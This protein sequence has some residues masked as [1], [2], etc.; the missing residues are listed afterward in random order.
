MRGIRRVTVTAL[1]SVVTVALMG[2]LG[3]QVPT[4]P[5]AAAIT[6][7]WQTTAGY[8]PLTNVSAVSCAPSTTASAT[9]CVAV[10]DNGH[11][12]A[13]IIVTQNGGAHLVG[14]DSPIG[15]D[16]VVHR[17][18]SIVGRLLCRRGCGNHEVD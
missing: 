8:T 15:R 18:V 12:V 4:S 9:T 16:V 10:G 14:L 7:T 17:L 11:N 13:S 3:S 2:L 1:S 5:A 6:P